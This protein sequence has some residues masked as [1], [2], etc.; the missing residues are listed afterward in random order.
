MI[1][2]NSELKKL[3]KH[4]NEILASEGFKDIESDNPDAP[5][6]SSAY[7]VFTKYPDGTFEM[8]SEYS[9]LAGQFLHEFEF[10]SKRDRRIW[11]L[12]SDGSTVREIAK[13]VRLHHSSVVR[14]LTKLKRELFGFYC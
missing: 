2:V 3:R 14:T 7:D 12:H 8:G 13:I 5:L 4:W 6:K 10:E 1:A 11:E 9:R